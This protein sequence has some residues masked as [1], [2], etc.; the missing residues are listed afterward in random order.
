[1]DD[2]YRQQ[3]QQVKQLF[4]RVAEQKHPVKGCFLARQKRIYHNN[5][6]DGVFI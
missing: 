2:L 4:S 6:F 3:E 5:A 1:M